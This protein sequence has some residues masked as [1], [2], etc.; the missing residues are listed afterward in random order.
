M[1]NDISGTLPTTF[2]SMGLLNNLAIDHN[3]LTGT[4]PSGF[5]D[6]ALLTFLSISSNSLSGQYVVSILFSVIYVLRM[7]LICRFYS[8]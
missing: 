2:V 5:G 7:V 1:M 4:V 3:S 8:H 6:L